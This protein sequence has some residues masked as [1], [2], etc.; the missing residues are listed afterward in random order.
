MTAK[1]NGTGFKRPL[2]AALPQQH[3]VEEIRREGRKAISDRSSETERK[4]YM[5]FDSTNRHVWGPSN[6]RRSGFHSLQLVSLPV[7]MMIASIFH[8]CAVSSGFCC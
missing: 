6:H 4:R 3:T 8:N 2:E 1:G 7:L 5:H